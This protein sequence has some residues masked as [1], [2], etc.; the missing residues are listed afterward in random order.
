MSSRRGINF[1]T[2]FLV[3]VSILS[4]PLFVQASGEVSFSE[5]NWAGSEASSADEWL[6]LYNSSPNVIDLTGWRVVDLVKEKTLLTVESGQVA[7]G[8]HF[9]IAN[10]SQE[11]EFSNG[12]SSLNTDPDIVDSNLSLSNTKFKLGLFNDSG[13]LIDEVG[14]GK[15]P[16]AGNKV[17]FISMERLGDQWVDSQSSINLKSGLGSPTNSGRPQVLEFSCQLIFYKSLW[18]EL[19]IPV[20]EYPDNAITKV[21][22]NNEEQELDLV[23]GQLKLRPD[24]TFENLKIEL[25]ASNGLSD[26]KLNHC[27]IVELSEQLALNEVFP[28]PESG[29][30]EFVEI[31]NS[32]SRPVSLDGWYLDDLVTSGSKPF[33]LN[34]I[35][36]D[37]RSYKVVELNELKLNN[38]GDDVNLIDPLGSVVD[39][40]SFPSS[41]R[42]LSWSLYKGIWGWSQP[43]PKQVQRSES[44]GIIR[45]G[46]SNK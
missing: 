6:E 35:V 34:G 22:I 19:F 24:K 40:V 38:S 21:L 30:S 39:T 15:S 23:D 20:H 12:I 44:K 31:Y 36:I 10:N 27:P 28:N 29:Q 7:P 9:L 18:R 45:F 5:I 37:P 43:T 25:V 11:H 8:G 42:G 4:F 3:G 13:Q 1:I 46:K 16:T 26:I 41:S 32:S 2:G 14:N 17:D 33:N